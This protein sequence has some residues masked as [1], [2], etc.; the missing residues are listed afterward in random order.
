MFGNLFN[1]APIG[2]EDVLKLAGKFLTDGNVAAGVTALTQGA[3]QLQAQHGKRYILMAEMD[4]H[5]HIVASAHVRHNDGSTELAGAVNLS[6]LTAAPLKAL[7]NGLA[8][9]QPQSTTAQ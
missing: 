5:G 3:A 6:N 4:A 2:M 9:E 1:G 7:L 8:T